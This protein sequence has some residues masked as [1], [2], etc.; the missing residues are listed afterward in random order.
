[1]PG[2]L[3]HPCLAGRRGH[4]SGLASPWV[5][6]ISQGWDR[7]SSRGPGLRSTLHTSALSCM[8]V[9][10]TGALAAGVGIV[11]WWEGRGQKAGEIVG[12]RDPNNV[13]GRSRSPAND[14]GMVNCIR[15]FP[16]GQLTQKLGPRINI[17]LKGQALVHALTTIAPQGVNYE[18]R[19]EGKLKLIPSPEALWQ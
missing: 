2:T 3:A 11:R 10:H 12:R 13:R 7:S 15:S 4:S 8:L 9:L 18:L 19:L 14:A 16:A 5:S 6:I 17:V 1:M